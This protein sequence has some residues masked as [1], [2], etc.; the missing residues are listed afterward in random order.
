M[1]IVHN[2]IIIPPLTLLQVGLTETTKVYV[3]TSSEVLLFLLWIA[4][5]E[6]LPN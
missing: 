6:L 4:V 2:V 5:K 1:N 3:S